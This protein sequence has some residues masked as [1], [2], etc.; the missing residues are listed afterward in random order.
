MAS[1]AAKLICPLLAS[2]ARSLPIT[3]PK[4]D[5]HENLGTGTLWDSVS[6]TQGGRVSR[7]R[8]RSRIHSSE[9]LSPPGPDDSLLSPNLPLCQVHNL[10]VLLTRNLDVILYT[11]TPTDHPILPITL[12]GVLPPK[13]FWG[14]FQSSWRILSL[15][16]WT[17]PWPPRPSGWSP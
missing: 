15:P 5:V 9:S 11:L 17:P 1:R 14:R 8:H 13:H 7:R 3:E 10:Q 12:S 4:C 6:V 2:K 16:S